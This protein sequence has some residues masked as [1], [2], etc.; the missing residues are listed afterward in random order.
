MVGSAYS[1]ACLGLVIGDG[2]V[3]GGLLG[4]VFEGVQHSSGFGLWCSGA[5]LCRSVTASLVPF[6]MVGWVYVMWWVVLSH[7][8]KYTDRV[9]CGLV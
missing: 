6:W 7:V 5:P 1:V 4:C 3:I 8:G 2:V 9:C